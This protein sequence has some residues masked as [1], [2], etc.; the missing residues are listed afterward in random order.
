MNGYL[1]IS[2]YLGNVEINNGD[3]SLEKYGK[4]QQLQQKPTSSIV[5]PLAQSVS[6]F[7]TRENFTPRLKTE[8]Q[9]KF[10]DAVSVDP[11]I[12]GP[13]FWYTLHTSAAF[14]PVEASPIVQERMKQR[15]LAIP[16]EI[17]CEK[18]RTHA[19]AFVEGRK[20]L[21]HAVSGKESLSKFY[22]DFHNLVNQRYGKPVWTYEQALQKYGGV[23][24]TKLN[25]AK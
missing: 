7:R 16:Y 24:K 5:R 18:C 11:K 20:D 1:T 14:Y 12:W 3:L 6:T 21:D 4:P 17:P 25:Y 10:N 8:I 19:L 2:E 23:N 22:V 13:H 15:I 9:E